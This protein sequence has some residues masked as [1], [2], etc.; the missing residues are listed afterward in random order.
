MEKLWG[1][2]SKQDKGRG[3]F[4]N[5]LGHEAFSVPRIPEGTIFPHKFIP[6]PVEPEKL[7]KAACVGAGRVVMGRRERQKG[8]LAPSSGPRDKALVLIV[9]S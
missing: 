4:H 1:Y 7:Q 9:N 6:N 2:K 5:H 3:K 8:I